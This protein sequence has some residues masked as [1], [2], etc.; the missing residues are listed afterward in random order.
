[1]LVRLKREYKTNILND[2]ILALICANRTRD[3]II[4]VIRMYWMEGDIILG[5][6][7]SKK[8]VVSAGRHFSMAY[9]IV[10]VEV[11]VDMAD[12]ILVAEDKGSGHE[13]IEAA[14]RKRGTTR[15]VFIRSF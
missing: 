9:G 11:I 4:N 14:I 13:H 6:E 15:M 10:P 2:K 7:E 8:I 5:T 3:K 12:W 1:M